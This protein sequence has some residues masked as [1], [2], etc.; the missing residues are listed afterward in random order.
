MRSIL[1]ALSSV[2][3]GSKGVLVNGYGLSANA[4]TAGIEQRLHR[5]P[6]A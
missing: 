3:Y 4:V 6:I 2:K 1:Y 5:W